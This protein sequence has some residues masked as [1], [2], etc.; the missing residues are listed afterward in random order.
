MKF[1][2]KIEDSINKKIVSSYEFIKEQVPASFYAKLEKLKKLP[3]HYALKAKAKLRI[4]GLKSI[5]YPLHYLELIKTKSQLALSFIKEKKYKEIDLRA[6]LVDPFFALLKSPG[7][8]MGLTLALTVTVTASVFIYKNISVI[9]KETMAIRAP[10][11][12]SPEDLF[13]EI[14]NLNYTTLLG[15]EVTFKM[16]LFAKDQE[17]VAELEK[18]EAEIKTHLLALNFDLKSLP[19]PKEKAHQMEKHI[20]EAIGG[21]RVESVKVIQILKKRPDYYFQSERQIT[22]HNLNL[23]IFLEDSKRNRQVIITFTV[24]TSNRSTVLKLKEFEI[25]ARDHLNMNVEPVILQLPLDDESKEIIKNKIREELQIFLEANNIKGEIV[26]I[27]IN[28]LL[29]S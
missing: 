6:S 20:I 7:K 15:E 13:V 12:A 25:P 22:F 8:L 23:Q 5:G 9:F 17:T 14:K 19:L 28:E 29:A 18:M 1:L 26:D 16:K 2:E 11:S 27:Y 24:L 10:A 4:F 3:K 21:K